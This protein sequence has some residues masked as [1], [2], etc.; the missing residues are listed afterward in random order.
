MKHVL[1]LS[2]RQWAEYVI[3]IN[4]SVREKF[5]RSRR[6]GIFFIDLQVAYITGDYFFPDAP[7][8]IIK[9]EDMIY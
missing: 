6:K 2:S 9:K 3:A 4:L 8:C 5:L 7:G 1:L